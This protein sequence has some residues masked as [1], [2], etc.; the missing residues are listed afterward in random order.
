MSL[1]LPRA[2]Q[3]AQPTLVLRWSWGR[4]KYFIDIGFWIELLSNNLWTRFVLSSHG[5]PIVVP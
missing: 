4:S 3:K 5:S 2:A 1:E